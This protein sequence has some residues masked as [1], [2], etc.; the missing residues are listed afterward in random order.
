MNPITHG[1]IGWIISQP[2]RSRNDRRLVTLAAVTPDI[3]GLGIFL[4]IEYYTKLHHT[5]GHNIFFGFILS[6]FFS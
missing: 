1:M 6:L 4:G 5:F 3:D 2:L